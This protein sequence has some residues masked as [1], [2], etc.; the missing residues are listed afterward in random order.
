MSRW[1]WFDVD[2]AEAAAVAAA[3]RAPAAPGANGLSADCK[4]SRAGIAAGLTADAWYP[5]Y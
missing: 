2:V 1:F 4:N 3:A 5:V